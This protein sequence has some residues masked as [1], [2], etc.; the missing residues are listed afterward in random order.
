MIMNYKNNLKFSIMRFIKLLLLFC[1]F[2]VYC[3]PQKTFRFSDHKI[4]NGI[5]S[6]I[7]SRDINYLE[8]GIEVE[9]FFQGLNIYPDPI[10]KESYFVKI[11][12]F[13]LNRN[14]GEPAY[15]LR[16]DCF[17]L[18]KGVN[19]KAVLVDSTI[20]NLPIEI[21]P[22]RKDL[23][24]SDYEGYNISNVFAIKPFNGFFPQRAIYNMN[25]IDYRNYEL[26]KVCITPI[27][28]N[29]SGKTI[30]VAKHLKY[31]VTWDGYSKDKCKVIG[32]KYLDQ[33]VFL[34][35]TCINY[36]FDNLLDRSVN[37]VVS[38]YLIV[39]H[40]NFF[41][42][43]TKFSKWKKILGYNVSITCKS[44]WSSDEIK[45]SVIYYYNNLGSLD[46]LLIIGDHDYVP[47]KQHANGSGSFYS[48]YW[49]GCVT[50][51]ENGIADIKRGR[52]PVATL[53]EAYTIID[54]IIGYEY[55]PPTDSVFYKN[56]LN[57]AY[58]QD[59][60]RY[61]HNEYGG[62][63][64]IE[65]RRFLKTSEEIRDYMKMQG[66]NIFRVYDANSLSDP[67]RYNNDY[68]S[69]GDSIP[70]ELRRSRFSWNGNYHDIIERVNSGTFYVCHRD[71][72]GIDC[73]G[74]PRIYNSHVSSLTNGNRLPVV[75]SINCL[76]GN[77]AH[78]SDCFAEA[79]LKNPNGGCVAII[80][81]T[82]ETLSGYNDALVEGIFNSVWP[83]PGLMPVFPN[84]TSNSQNQD[85]PLYKLGY[86]L[87]NGFVKMEETYGPSIS[88]K[89]WYHCL[90]DPSMQIYTDKP[91]SFSLASVSRT[92]NTI[93]VQTGEGNAYIVFYDCLNE[94]MKC[95]YA[96]SMQFCDSAYDLHN[97]IVC[98]SLHNKIPFIDNA[99]TLYLQDELITGVRTF[100][101]PKVLIGSD[102]TPLKSNG[103][104]IIQN[105]TTTINAETVEIKNDTS[106]EIGSRLRINTGNN[107]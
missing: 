39:T 5:S 59:E 107:E 27:K 6:T 70:A 55:N 37:P 53:E 101:S 17:V 51:N 73:W 86:I 81:A 1:S 45:D 69:F 43:A 56:G 78:S 87:D 34:N 36:G 75:F 30:S 7:P 85:S 92:P 93:N 20:I 12:G 3:Y 106:V 28:Y 54:K 24:D 9:Y 15:P 105:G 49:Y 67:V 47:A 71:H 99:S 77:F 38:N 13:G 14:E 63:D 66:K 94:K 40:P 32:N 80:A 22:S 65:S 72:G 48:D 57:C 68:Y 98:I 52:L 46:Y 8:E 89:R 83:S 84:H 79:F 2:F 104:V 91:S 62:Y 42:A 82:D 19:A 44:N 103:P 64:G 21:S 100:N 29:Y 50:G 74:D 25:L 33:D 10:F 35:N 96:S 16:W 31:L 61:G 23:S 11:D 102:V 97:T 41:E 58:F 4:T 88:T 76:T 18:P 90:G 26:C 95:Y 60:V